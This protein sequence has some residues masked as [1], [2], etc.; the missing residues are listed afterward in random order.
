MCGICGFYQLEG[1]ADKQVL[2]RMNDR[3]IHRGPDDD[4]YYYED[5]SPFP[6]NPADAG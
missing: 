4:G 5:T 2:K 1:E 3:I 6:P